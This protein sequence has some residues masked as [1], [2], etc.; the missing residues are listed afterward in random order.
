MK[1]VQ[2]HVPKGLFSHNI[3][4]SI[5]W[6]DSTEVERQTGNM[7]TTR[8]YEVWVQIPAYALFLITRIVNLFAQHTTTFREC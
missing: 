6:W 7:K 1:N 3:I 2:F 4:V 8:S 5:M